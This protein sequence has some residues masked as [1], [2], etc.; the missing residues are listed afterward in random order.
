[1]PLRIPDSTVAARA[2]TRAGDHVGP[3][4]GLVPGFAQAS[5]RPHVDFD[6]QEQVHDDP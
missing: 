6:S 5:G 2:S 4:S 1:M 3:T